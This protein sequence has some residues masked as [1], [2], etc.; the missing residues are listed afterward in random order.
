MIVAASLHRVFRPSDELAD[1]GTVVLSERMASLCALAMG[2][3]RKVWYAPFLGFFNGFDPLAPA[4]GFS[5]V[6]GVGSSCW[7]SVQI[8]KKLCATQPHIC[9][10]TYLLVIL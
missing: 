5:E 8:T 2:G 10:R 4:S 1:F 7:G 6:L 3:L 9:P